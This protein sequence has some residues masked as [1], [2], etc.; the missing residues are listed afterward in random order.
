MMIHRGIHILWNNVDIFIDKFLVIFYF[1]ANFVENQWQ[2]SCIIYSKKKFNI[3]SFLDEIVEEWIE[4]VID[5]D[6][7]GIW[8]VFVVI[9]FVCSCSDNLWC[10][11]LDRS[12]KVSYFE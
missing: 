8:I 5:S 4:S 1:V 7:F 2:K 11:R 12:K 6:L 3:W 10:L 9:D